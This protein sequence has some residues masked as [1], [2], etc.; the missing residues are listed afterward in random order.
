MTAPDHAIMDFLATIFVNEF[1]PNSPVKGPPEE[2]LM[3]IIPHL[4]SQHA[5][6]FPNLSVLASSENSKLTLLTTIIC[7]SWPENDEPTPL[8]WDILD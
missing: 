1:F 3:K 8:F 4:S 7:S 6:M 5:W 2:E